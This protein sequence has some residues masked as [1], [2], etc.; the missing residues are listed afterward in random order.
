[1]DALNLDAHQFGGHSTHDVDVLR[2]HFSCGETPINR[3]EDHRPD[4]PDFELILS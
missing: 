1:M 3:L 4:G 2:S